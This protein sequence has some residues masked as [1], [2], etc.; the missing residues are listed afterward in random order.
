MLGKT[1]NSS[2][3]ICEGELP[4]DG[5]RFE[6][7]VPP[8]VAAPS[9]SIRKRASKLIRL[10]QYVI[11]GILTETAQDFILESVAERKNILISGGTGSGKTTLTNAILAAVVDE[12]PNDRIITIEDTYELQCAA[13]NTVPLHTSTD[14]SMQD[15]LKA[16]LR[17]R[18]DRIIVGEVRGSE[19]LS[20]LKAWN[21]GHPGGC[22]TVHSNDPAS[23]LQRIESL[24]SEGTAG[25]KHLPQLIASA[26]DVVIQI[27]RAPAGRA[28]THVAKVLSFDGN[29]Y[30]T[31][32]LI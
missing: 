7:L 31:E 20:L 29:S 6:G 32:N 5:S 23:A 24:A 12:H 3:P 8:L 14:V 22:C 16:T 30:I 1:T 11:D 25:T 17:L 9:F 18:P 15:L 19:A 26:V 13:K 4:I 27:A 28:V 21:T 10:D 2:S